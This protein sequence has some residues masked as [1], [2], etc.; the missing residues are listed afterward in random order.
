MRLLKIFSDKNFKNVRLNEHFNVVLAKI[1]DKT[2]KNDTHNLGKTSLIHVINFLLLGEFQKNKGLLSNSIFYGQTFYLE[3]KLN[4]GQHLI[5]RRD[6][7]SPSKISF[8]LNDIELNNFIPPAEWDEE[9]MAFD[10]AKEKLNEYLDFDVLTNWTYRKSITYFLRT[11][12][13]YLDVYQLNKFKGRHIDWKPFVFELLGFNGKLRWKFD[14][15]GLLVE[16]P[17][18][19]S[20]D[21][22]YSVK[23]VRNNLFKN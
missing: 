1:Q 12:Q 17:E 20:G 19:L 15:E 6:I 10:K 2:N 5:I 9:D 13:D 16:M 23:I 18:N 22:A 11:Q 8:K 7:N 3:I 21:Y 4:N 14:G